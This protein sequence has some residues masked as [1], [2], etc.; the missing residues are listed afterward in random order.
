MA[1]EPSPPVLAE[2]VAAAAASRRSLRIGFL[3][4]ALGAVLFASKGVIIKLTYAEG[5]DAETLLGL[6][7]GLALPIY[8]AIGAM[9]LRDRARKGRPLP[10]RRLAVAT[11]LV[12]VLGYFVAS[13]ADFL[14]LEH[15]SAQ[16]ERMILFTFPLFVVVFGAVFFGLPASRAALVAIGLSYIGLAVIFV[17][18]L[19]AFGSDVVLGAGFVL[20]AAISFAFYQLLAKP[21]IAVV[22]PRLFTCIAMSSAATVALV[23][24]FVT[25]PVAD[26]AVSATAFWYTVLL[27]LGATVAPSFLL[28]AAL[29]RISAQ[30]N[31]TIG[32]LSPIV[33]IIL[34]WF[35][36][37]ERLS[38][39]DVV[40]VA[41]VLVGVGWMTLRDSRGPA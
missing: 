26:L 31:A 39:T 29:H 9:S 25:H 21:L 36:L 7:L 19:Q 11:A 28:A 32:M 37:D 2:P 6:R 17:S 3:F 40:G 24:F 23:Q 14:G 20:V 15:I 4:A 30:A 10:T 27:T 22:G 41:L 13:Y 5:V 38:A 34:A 33:T 16:F 18:R 12:G 1:T 35:V 8:L